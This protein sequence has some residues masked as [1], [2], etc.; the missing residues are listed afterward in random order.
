M[1]SYS[2]AIRLRFFIRFFCGGHCKREQLNGCCQLLC[3]SGESIVLPLNSFSIKT[4]TGAFLQI[5]EI[6]RLKMEDQRWLP[7]GNPDAIIKSYDII[8]SCCGPQKTSLGV[9]SI[10]LASIAFLLAKLWRWR[11]P[12]P[13]PTPASEYKKARSR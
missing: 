5:S 2:V 10:L 8:N 13:P 12:P 4:V 9:L 3:I 1:E 6:Q 7:F 11:N